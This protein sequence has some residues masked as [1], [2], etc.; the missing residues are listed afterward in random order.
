MSIITPFP[1]AT[2]ISLYRGIPWDNTYADIRWFSSESER[3]TFLNSQL[4]GQWGSCSIVKTGQTIKLTGQ[5]TDWM[6]CNYMSFINNGL[7]VGKTF[8]AFI[9]SVNYINNNTFEVEYEIDWI[10]SYLFDID[11]ETCLVE[12]EHVNDDTFG[13][14][15]LQE[16]IGFGEYAVEYVADNTYEKAINVNYLADGYE[17]EMKNHSGV[18]VGLNRVTQKFPEFS[19]IDTVLSN[20]NQTGQPE[21]VASLQMCAWGMNN[22]SGLSDS[23]QTTQSDKSFAYGNQT[24]TAKNNKMRCYPYKV[25]TVD[26]YDGGV[27]QYRY[28]EFDDSVCS[29]GV[30]GTLYPK[31]A[32]MCFPI[33]YKGW[34]GNSSTPNTMRQNSLLFTNFPEIPW[35]SDTFRAWV[36]QNTPNLILSSAGKIV[37]TVGGALAVGVGIATANPVA[38][39]GGASATIGG[40]SGIAEERQNIEQHQLHSMSLQGS[41][42]SAGLAY[43]QNTIGFRVTKYCLRPDDAKRIDEY[44]T[45]YGYKVDTVKVP[46]ITGRQYVNFVKTTNAHVKGNIPVDTKDILEKAMNGGCSFWHV[47]DIGQVLTDNPIVT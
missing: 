36:T 33:N 26:N 16:N 31:P 5:Q 18:G 17:A 22:E 19:V 25:L 10:Q 6:S 43:L 14:Y 24:Y 11:F 38:V 47:N 2:V 46:N 1:Q 9:K 21:R 27:E 23:F 35:V 37:Q 44:F 45:R 28:E 8:F 39:V 30:N 42:N 41:T 7:G 13:K 29:F 40:L 32:M 34:H 4:A 15:L 3:T 12:R 20:L